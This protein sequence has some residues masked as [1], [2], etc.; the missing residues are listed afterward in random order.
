M[1]LNI[2]LITYMHSLLSF[3]FLINSDTKQWKYIFKEKCKKGIVHNVLE[4]IKCKI[5]SELFAQCEEIRSLF[6]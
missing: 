2:N 1:N 4:L 5:E 6:L 3:F